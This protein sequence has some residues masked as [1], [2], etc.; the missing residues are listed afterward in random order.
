MSGSYW[1]GMDADLLVEA[2]A[3]YVGNKWVCLSRLVRPADLH[4]YE[5]DV[6]HSTHRPATVGAGNEYWTEY[7]I[8]HESALGRFLVSQST[9]D[10]VQFVVGRKLR[11]RTRIWAQ[12]YQVGER[13]DWHRDGDGEVQL[14]V[15]IRSPDR[16]CGGD[17]CLKI[18]NNELRLTL[19]PGDCVLFKATDLLH[20][21]TRILS[22]SAD[23]VWPRITAV[24]RFFADVDATH[25]Q[26][27]KLSNSH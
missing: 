11:R 2:R 1:A 7:A 21:T 22:S 3:H 24:A 8:S 9:R 17:F 15:C 14:L 19:R 5:L 10:V 23:V 27:I 18:D 20:G 25:E 16:G 12:S 6:L 26:Q 13:A 4:Q